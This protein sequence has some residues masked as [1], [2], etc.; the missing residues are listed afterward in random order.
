MLYKCVEL[1]SFFFSLNFY[2]MNFEIEIWY[3]RTYFLSFKCFCQLKAYQWCNLW[4]SRRLERSAAGDQIGESRRVMTRSDK[5]SEAERR[6][7][8]ALETK[9]S[10]SAA[11]KCEFKGGVRDILLDPATGSQNK[12][13]V[14]KLT[15]QHE[16]SAGD[17]IFLLG[18]MK[19][20][21]S[22][23]AFGV[24]Y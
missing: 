6:E 5:W 20:G 16:P 7:A 9:K 2:F 18:Y 19:A 3:G 24:L 11:K 17:R 13:L 14:C 10:R 8:S 23:G 1:V 21:P 22:R 12:Q 4:W 15:A